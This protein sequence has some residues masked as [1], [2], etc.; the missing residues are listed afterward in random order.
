MNTPLLFI[1]SSTNYAKVVP[2]F[3]LA[4]MNNARMNIGARVCVDIVLIALG[5][6]PRSGS[7]GHMATLYH[8]EEVPNCPK[9][10]F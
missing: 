9:W 8:F 6:I 5:Y 1:Y 3:F 7:L 2:T 4:I 10:H